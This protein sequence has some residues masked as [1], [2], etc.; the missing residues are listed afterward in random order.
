[1]D[2]YNNLLDKLKEKYKEWI[3]QLKEINDTFLSDSKYSNPYY[4]GIQENW[5]NEKRR[6]LIVGEEGYFY[7]NSGNG[8][9]ASH[10]NGK[11]YDAVN[12]DCLDTLMS[13]SKDCLEKQL[14]EDAYKSKFEYCRNSSAFW[15]W[16]RAIYSD[17]VSFVWTEL[18]KIC[19]EKEREN[20]R[21]CLSAN[22]ENL[23]HSTVIKIL[24]EEVRILE[25]THVIFL[26]WYRR[27]LQAEWP[28]LYTELYN[29]QS[30]WRNKKLITLKFDNKTFLFS[31]HPNRLKNVYKDN[32][33]NAFTA[34]I[35]N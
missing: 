35:N 26:G 1:M 19:K 33:I 27:S 30:I 4:A 18:D 8:K 31:Y 6:V 22:E 29:E 24:R 16:I 32:F 14:K 13:W 34:L 28:E 12:Y 20:D 7:N 10:G 25:P 11:N 5:C 2:K 17:N 9:L 3:S 15:S 21:C 23:L